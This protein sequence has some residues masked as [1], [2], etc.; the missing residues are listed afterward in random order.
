MLLQNF[1]LEIRKKPQQTYIKIPHLFRPI[2]PPPHPAPEGFHT[3]VI[4][5]YTAA[6]QN[7]PASRTYT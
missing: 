2:D 3:T 6:A 5:W 7:L 4:K 1:T